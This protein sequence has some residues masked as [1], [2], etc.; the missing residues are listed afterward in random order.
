MN[1]SKCGK[2][3]ITFIRYNGRYLC[4]EHFNEFVEKRVKREIRKQGLPKGK[5]AVAL[6]GGKDSLVAC[7]LIWK[8]VK[9]DRNRILNAI[10]VDEGIKNYREKTIKIARDFCDEYRI[11]HQIISFKEEFGFTLDEV[12]KVRK[13]LAE[14][15]Y[16][17]V[18]RRYC[19]NVSAKRINAS[20]I[21]MG[22]NLDD[23]SQTI[24]M[25]FVRGDMERM[26]RMAPH[27]KIQPDLI[28]RI[29]PL[30]SIPEK[31]TTLYAYVKGFE[32]S[33]NECPY[34]IRAMRGIY[35]DFLAQ[36]E[37]KHSGSRHSILKSFFEIEDCLHNK[38]S[39]A[40]LNP[41]IKC[42][43]P[44]SEKICMACQL[45]E[46]VKKRLKIDSFH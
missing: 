39:P 24:L 3:S 5:I 14:C 4:K 11:S 1:C 31:E 41:C 43:E 6:S 44:S 46:K 28:P 16:C 35:R 42:G 32:I 12:S 34:A 18:F 27:K 37:E 40:N 29:L 26:A 19:L 15:T 8:I 13:N 9:N 38:F 23:V 25:N 2:K 36:L 17:G 7:Y 45:S 20:A 33:E 10:T 22:H 30:R 21:A